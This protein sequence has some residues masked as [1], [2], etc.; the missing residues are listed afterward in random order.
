MS[1]R[2][3]ERVPLQVLQRGWL[4]A[5]FSC[6]TTDVNLTI[7]GFAT[8]AITVSICSPHDML[9]VDA[10]LRAELQFIGSKAYLFRDDRAQKHLEG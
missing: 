10:E 4:P 2:F 8:V 3:E 7:D 1:G 6:W 9:S 5:I